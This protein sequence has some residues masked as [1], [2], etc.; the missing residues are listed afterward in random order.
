MFNFR[1][2]IALVACLSVFDSY[3]VTARQTAAAPATSARAAVRGA[4][5]AASKGTVGARAAVRRGGTAPVAGGKPAVSAR[6]ATTQ[7]VVQSGTKVSTA[8]KNIVVSEE[9]QAKWEGC[10]DSFCMMD[11]ANGG[12]CVCS[13]KNQ[14]LNIILAEIEKLDQQS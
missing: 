10:M 5:P 12:R 3:A 6:A 14:E 8:A 13:D 4:A 7:K 11:N 2:V 1:F 9:C